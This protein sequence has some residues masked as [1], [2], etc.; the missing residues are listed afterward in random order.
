[1]AEQSIMELVLRRQDSLRQQS[2]LANDPRE[3]ERCLLI[4]E[5][6]DA[7]IAEI[8]DC[9]HLKHEQ[10]REP[11]WAEDRSEEWILGDLGQFGG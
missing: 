9:G 7:L 5:E 2:R 11:K 10:H 1:M 4:A 8:Q 3:A 6:Y